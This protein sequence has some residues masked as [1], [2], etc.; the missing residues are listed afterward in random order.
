ML[1]S[2]LAEGLFGA[3]IGAVIAGLFILY[4][5]K[6]LLAAERSRREN[7]RESET[8]SVAAA[9]L[10]EID[11]FYKLSVRDVCRALKDVNPKDLG[12]HVKSATYKPFVVF[13]A[14]ANKVGLFDPPLIAGIIGYYGVSR[15]YLNTISDYGEA[16]TQ[17]EGAMQSHMRAKPIALLAQIIESSEEMV[18][19]TQTVCGLLAAR[20]GTEYTFNAP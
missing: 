13:Q 4:Q 1:I 9:L 20:A 18:P 7:E 6:T 10:W 15:A 2:P 16:L 8:K 12:F 11:D 5:T 3:I 17:Y 14:L 19:L